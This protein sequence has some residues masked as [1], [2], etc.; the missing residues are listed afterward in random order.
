MRIGI[1]AHILG[2][3]KGG[4]ETFLFQV[5]RHLTKID[6]ENEYFIYV[7]K[8]HTLK[9]EQLASSFRIL[10]LPFTNPWF[11]RLLLL[12]YVYR[13]D[14]LDVIHTQRALPLW[15]CKTSVLQVCDV[16]YETN[17]GSFKGTATLIKSYLFRRSASRA[18]CIA[19]LSNASRNDI[20]KY[21]GVSGEKILITGAAV[22][23]SAFYV[24]NQAND[25]RFDRY[26]T[27]G[28]FILFAGLL[29]RNKNI[30]T[31]IRAF[32]GLRARRPEFES[33]SL[34]IVGGERFETGTGYKQELRRLVEELDL[35]GK[36]VF[37][38]YVPGRDLRMFMNRARMVVCPSLAEGFG[39]PPLEAMACGTPVIASRIPA[40]EEVC[41]DAALFVDPLD[42]EGLACT[43]EHILK[44]E[45]LSEELVR[46]GLRRS[47]QFTWGGTAA[48]LLEV[49]KTAYELGRAT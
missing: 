5:I 24:D 28:A 39:L 46:N 45:A 44:D 33:L 1:D 40:I 13:R 7:D 42:V 29:E 38:G 25:F 35:E 32:S 6:D 27:L 31:L 9:Q 11:Q 14:R 26:A 10:V 43:M 37:T 30:H 47:A 8:R 23:P 15:G 2:K 17:P 36:V 21:Y 34:V 18:T 4:V 3:K 49:Y 20:V 19:T 41:A 16:D 22:D 12:P 48:R